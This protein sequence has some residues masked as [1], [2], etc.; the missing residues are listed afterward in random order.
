MDSK[1]GKYI[2]LGNMMYSDPS[3]SVEIVQHYIC[4]FDHSSTSIALATLC[5][6]V[7]NLPKNSRGMERNKQ[8]RNLAFAIYVE[9]Q[10]LIEKRFISIY[11]QRIDKNND[12]L[13]KWILLQYS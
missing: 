3:I 9:S 5:L 13:L 12:E 7:T 1:R 6:I 2:Q 4:C 11:L 8:G 10:S